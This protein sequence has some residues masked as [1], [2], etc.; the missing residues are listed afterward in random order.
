MLFDHEAQAFLPSVEL[1]FS[2]L[3][4]TVEQQIEIRLPLLI[5]FTSSLAA[6]ITAAHLHLFLQGKP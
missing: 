1:Q 6:P 2:L 4:R 5:T 3:T